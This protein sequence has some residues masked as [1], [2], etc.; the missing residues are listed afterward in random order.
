M[1]FSTEFQQFYVIKYTIIKYTIN[2][3]QRVI[4]VI[5]HNVFK[6]SL[7]IRKYPP[8]YIAI[9]SLPYKMLCL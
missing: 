3:E 5:S 2:Y 8:D 4:K 1:I 7:G 9:F 6:T